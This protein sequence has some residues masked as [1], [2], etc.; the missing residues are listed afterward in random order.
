[1][2][3]QLNV[4][5]SGFYRFFLYQKGSHSYNLQLN[6]AWK[7]KSNNCFTA[8]GG[9]VVV[10]GDAGDLVDVEED[11]EGLEEVDQEEGEEIGK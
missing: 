11:E 7:S 1:M 10:V 6:F 4:I 8:R 9:K 5:T 2:H 3:R